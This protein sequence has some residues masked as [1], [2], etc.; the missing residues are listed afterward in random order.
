MKISP[1]T[2]Y[3]V[4]I[5][6]ALIV[7][8]YAFFFQWS[9]NMQ[10]ASYWREYR[11]QLQAEAAKLDRAEQRVEQARELVEERAAQWQNI[12]AARTPPQSVAQGG[13]NLAVNPWQLSVD[14][15]TFRNNVQRAV[16]AQLRRGGVRVV[17]GPFVPAPPPELPVNQLLRDHYNY[18]AFPFPVV[19]YDLG[20]VTVQGTYEQITA[21]VRSW[22]NM[23]RFLAI[24]DNLQI[25]GTAPELTGTYNLQLV[26]FIRGREVFPS[27]PEIAVAAAPGGAV[28][29]GGAPGGAP[30]PAAP[31]GGG[32]IVGGIDGG[33]A[34]N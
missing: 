19:I 27:V 31:G 34:A 6:I 11:D 14:T 5:S 17:E 22:A 7:I 1:S 23:P 30:G 8:S 28:G 16:N 29:A 33:T 21:N 20:Q 24:A 18:P 4:G 10:N 25:A 9:P 15:R 26:A 13:I 3:I 12:V 32:M 2:I